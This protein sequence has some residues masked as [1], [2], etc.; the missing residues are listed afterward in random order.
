MDVQAERYA[1]LRAAAHSLATIS[2]QFESGAFDTVERPWS[3]ARQE[4]RMSMATLRLLFSDEDLD[5]LSRA[6]QDLDQAFMLL[7]AGP[8]R[9]NDEVFGAVAKCAEYVMDE[10]RLLSR[11]HVLTDVPAGETRAKRVK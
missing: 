2:A 8:R 3:A 11:S 6:Y 5:G 7:S 10:L 1:T 4:L 9:G